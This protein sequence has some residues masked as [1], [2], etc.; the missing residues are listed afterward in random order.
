MTVLRDI[1]ANE[2]PTAIYFSATAVMLAVYVV[3]ALS[4]LR[5]VPALAPQRQRIAR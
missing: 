5:P 1:F 2:L 3:C 4:V